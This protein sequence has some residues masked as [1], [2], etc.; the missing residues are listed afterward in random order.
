MYNEYEEEYLQV[1]PKEPAI[2][3]RSAN[4]E[5]KVAIQSQRA[6]IGKDNK[7]AEGDSLPLCYSS[8]ELI[9]HKIKA[10]KRKHKL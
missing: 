10:S 8:F 4:G 9:R 3:P 1:T 5:N 2:E 7:C 6:D